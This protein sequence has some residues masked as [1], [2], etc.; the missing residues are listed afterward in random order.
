MKIAEYND[1][2]S[3]LTRPGFNSGS[4]KKPTTLEELKKSG[5]IVTG[6]KYKP[7]NPK[8]IQSIRRF[9]IEHGFRKNKSDGG[10]L[11]P[12]PKP[13]TLDQFKQKA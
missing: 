12:E 3:Y 5:K 9:E 7:S 4:D 10:P 6:D 8:L 2:M 13:Y 11:V 1:M